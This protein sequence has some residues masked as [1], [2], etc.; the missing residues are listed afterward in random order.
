MR[1]KL[2]LSPMQYYAIRLQSA[3]NL[4]FYGDASVKQI[5]TICGFSSPPV[6]SRAFRRYFGHS[7]AE[8]RREFSGEQLQRFV[9]PAERYRL[10][11]PMP[12]A[13]SL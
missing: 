8:Y 6:F 5:A 4:L 10:M 11:G 7:P 12:S 2:G 1:R 9:P 3:R 13:R